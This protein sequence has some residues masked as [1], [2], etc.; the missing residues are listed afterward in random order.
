MPDVFVSY[1]W[2]NADTV[3]RLCRDLSRHGVEIWRDTE[4]L[5]PGDRFKE[6]I[7]TAIQNGPFFLA[8]FSR[9]SI[10]KPRAYMNEELSIAIEELRLR[11]TTR[12]WFIPV[13]LSE[14]EIPNLSIGGGA[15]LRDL[16]W[17]DLFKDWNTG[18]DKILRV[19][20]RKL[21]APGGIVPLDLVH[22][23]KKRLPGEV[24]VIELLDEPIELKR[25]RMGGITITV[26]RQPVTHCV[27]SNAGK[28]KLIEECITGREDVIK[29]LNDKDHEVQRFLTGKISDEKTAESAIFIKPKDLGVSL[30]W[31]SG[32]VLSLV[33]FMG[34]EWVPLF[35]RDIPPYGWN[36]SLGS[37]ERRFNSQ[38]QWD[39]DDGEHRHPWD[40]IQREFVEESIVINPPPGMGGAGKLYTFRHF[41]KMPGSTIERW[42]EH[43]YLRQA[44]DKFKSAK[45]NIPIELAQV[46]LK[47]EMTL[48][49]L[50]PAPR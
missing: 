24:F 5:F 7:R 50:E 21:P 26:D 11:Q 29:K 1:V 16:Y 6:V 45:Q 12:A 30:R 35:F 36:L 49:I 43:V 28:Q 31:A 48:K 41:A 10:L 39:D 47:P 14:C 13:R 42:K 44:S 40:F 4:E 32:G 38:G 15:Y 23:Y 9:E 20:R 17:V 27:I 2:E 33:R 25:D 37:T 19:L 34:Q 8:C 3:K 22:A 46:K 18:I